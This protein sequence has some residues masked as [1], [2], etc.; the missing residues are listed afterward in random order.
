MD[1]GW[2]A[3]IVAVVWGVSLPCWPPPAAPRCG[4]VNPKPERTIDTAK[5][6][7]SALKG[8]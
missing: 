4:S 7:P 1:A 6:I 8:N 5:E 2:A 3:L